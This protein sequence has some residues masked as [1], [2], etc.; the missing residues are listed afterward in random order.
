[1]FKSYFTIA[2]R[3]LSRNKAFSFINIFG[4]AVGLA[5]CLLIMLYIFDELSYD[6][7][8][9]KGDH[10]YRIA[11]VGGKQNDRWAGAP[12]PLGWTA[13]KELS[14]VEEVTRL[15]TFPDIKTMLLRYEG[16][17]TPRQFFESNGY[18][19]DS[20]F[21]T[22]FTYDFLYGKAAT[23]L[24]QPNSMVVSEQ[25]ALK[26][27][28]RANPLGKVMVITTPFGKMNYT[29]AGVFDDSRNKSHIPGNFFLSLRNMD[30][31]K[32]AEQQTNWATNNIFYTYVLLKDKTDPLLFEKHLQ[33]FFA[34]HAAPDLKAMGVSKTLFLQPVK[35]IYL[36][37]AIGGEIAANGN[38]T[39]LYILTSIAA[40]ILLIACINFMNLSTAR[41]EKR[42]KEVGVRKVIGAQR[43]SLIRQF[44]GESFIM[45]L[46]ALI[47]AIVLVIAFLPSFNNLTHKYL[48]PAD[49]PS[50]IVWIIGLTLGTGL[51]A[52][53]YPALYLSAF[54]PISVLKGKIINSFSAKAIRKGLVVFQFSI[55][56]CLVLGALVIWQQLSF[57]KDQDLGF[58]KDQQ[59]ILPLELGFDNS[60]ANY[61]ALKNELLQDP[62]ITSVTCGSSYPG[63]T[64]IED[65]LF[66]PDGKTAND[67]VDIALSAIDH[68]YLKNLGFILASGRGFSAS[69]H[70]DSASIILNEKAVNG[71]GYTLDNAVGKNIHF[72]FK[73]QLYTFRII[74]VVKDFNFES[75]HS[76]IKP[77]AFTSGAFADKYSYLIA[78]FKTTDYK[79]LV[80][81]L[82]NIWYKINPNTPFEYSF[83]DQDFQ[84]NYKKEELAS[85][86]VVYFTAIAI[87]I[88]CLGLFGL[89]AFSAEQRVKEIGVRKVLGAS[90]KDVTILLSKDFVKLVGLAI[91]IA[92]PVGWFIMSKWLQGFAYRTPIHWWIFALAGSGAVIIALV[93]VS[94]QAI[95]AALAN[96]VRSLR[97]E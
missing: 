45:C 16:D 42:G 32:W 59:V 69:P 80:A 8:H 39:Y 87:F 92:S 22:I 63:I 91:L 30:M 50:L 46:L 96:P 40:F 82:G 18:Y 70:R 97:A 10:I 90:V 36:H 9:T 47:G 31:G 74:G 83:L 62:H 88:A 55:S 84:N 28:G 3:N 38:I 24:N 95:K 71:L 73:H 1:M 53:L 56:I 20:S 13:R 12:G 68:D 41:S 25:L 94:F 54:K 66:Y 15:L 61:T 7:Q 29:I 85:Q 93:T 86:I 51:L 35:N 81:S 60:E 49:Q 48:R 76:N 2:I 26:F 27:F 58:N 75:L 6:R 23:A 57:V 43:G 11:S 89:T 5:T 4:L 67:N 14:E 34:R 17:A 21:F 33:R 78:S 19:V 65:M 79:A 77:F 64:N 72:D 52:G 44:L 37:S